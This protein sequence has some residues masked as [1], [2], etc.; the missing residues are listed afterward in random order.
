MTS[1]IHQVL[2]T[3]AS[4]V[5][6]TSA[7]MRVLPPEEVELSQSPVS[8]AA[9]ISF[10]G[11]LEGRLIFAISP[12][13]LPLMVTSMLGLDEIEEIGEE[14]K[15]DALLEILNIICGNVL[16]EIHGDRPV[17]KLSPPELVTSEE[18]EAIIAT[19]PREN[20]A[21]FAVEN[22]RADLILLMENKEKAEG[23][24]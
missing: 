21:T 12:E 22:T 5:F 11:P 24:P 13:I 15:R 18:M 7:F 20:Q 10:S 9:S 23:T 19:A 2:M 6:E 17:F 8:L 3:V 14:A 4:R 1:D 16:T